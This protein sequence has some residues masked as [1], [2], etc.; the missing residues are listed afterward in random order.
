[1]CRP[2]FIAFD[3]EWSQQPTALSVGMVQIATDEFVILY[4]PSGRSFCP[5]LRELLTD[6]KVIKFGVGT[7]GKENEFL[8]C[9]D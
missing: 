9:G 6:R 8:W 7:K 5:C 4:R 3:L 2:R 1:M